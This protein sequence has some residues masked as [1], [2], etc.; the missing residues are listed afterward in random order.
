[1]NTG[2]K[3][4]LGMKSCDSSQKEVN[5]LL[6]S[7]GIPKKKKNELIIPIQLK[8]SNYFSSRIYNKEEIVYSFGDYTH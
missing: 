2:N 6:C 1:M 5:L 8:I 4:E 3:S 7:A